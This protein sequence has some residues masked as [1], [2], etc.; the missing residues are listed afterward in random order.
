MDPWLI[1]DK[2][3]YYEGIVTDDYWSEAIRNRAARYLLKY[4][5]LINS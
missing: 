5:N 3:A 1:E 2:I 4:K